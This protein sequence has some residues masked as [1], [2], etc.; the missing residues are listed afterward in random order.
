MSFY[1]S[2]SDEEPGML[3][4]ALDIEL[5]EDFDPTKTPVTGRLLI[6]KIKR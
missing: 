3:K 5:S 4:K 6:K 2:S 1:E